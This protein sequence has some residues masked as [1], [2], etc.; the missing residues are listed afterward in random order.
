[1]IKH[2]INL[3]LLAKIMANKKQGRATYKSNTT[4]VGYMHVNRCEWYETATDYW[5][6]A[7]TVRN[8]LMEANKRLFILRSLRKEGYSQA[9]IDYLFQSLVTLSLTYGLSVYGAVNAQLST[10]QCF[11]DQCHKRRNICKAVNI[12]DLLDKQDRQIF[13]KVKHQEKH[14]LRNLMPKLKVTEY[15][16]RHK[17]SHRPKLNTDRVKNSYFNRT[18]L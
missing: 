4:K 8:K 18:N 11:L 10:L 12:Y 2:A 6:L 3:I 16:L 7:F 17:S 15:N 9:E 13:D 5:T 1:M 14:P